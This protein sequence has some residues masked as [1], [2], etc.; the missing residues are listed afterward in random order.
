MYH[1]CGAIHPLINELI[2]IG[3]DI[4]NPVQVSAKEMDT[5][6]LKEQFGD[7]LTFWGGIDTRQVLPHGTVDDVKQEVKR[8][9]QDLAPGGGYVLNF[10]HNAQPDVK[11]E[12]ICAMFEAGR[13]YGMYPIR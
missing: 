7:R 11:P 3:V 4:L 1:S 10:V 9:I 5:H 8:V 13:E 6:V 12:N 2:E